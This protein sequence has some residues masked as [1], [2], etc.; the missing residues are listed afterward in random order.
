MLDADN[1]I[2]PHA[3]ERLVAALDSDPD[4]EFAYGILEKF[5]AT[6]GTDLMSWLPWTPRRFVRGNY[7]DATALIRRSALVQ[8]GGYTTDER[9]YGWE[10]FALWC[11]FADAGLRGVL[12]PEILARYRSGRISMI[13]LTNIDTSDAWSALLE[14]YAFLIGQEAADG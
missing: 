5:D 1:A 11:A 4:A 6:G 10:D 2:Y 13:S 3:I 7:I 12:V 8:V 9:L 14:R